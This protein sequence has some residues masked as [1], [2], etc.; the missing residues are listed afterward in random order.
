M[1][2]YSTNPAGK[3]QCPIC[4]YGSGADGK[5]RQSVSKHF[6]KIHQVNDLGSNT[7]GIQSQEDEITIEVDPGEEEE[8]INFTF[9]DDEAEPSWMDAG[10]LEAEEGEI[11]PSPMSAPVK[12]F[13]KSLNKEAGIKKG[14]KKRSAKEQLAWTAQQARLVRWGYVVIDRLVVWWGRGVL[15][16]PSWD[17]TRTEDEWK[18]M[19]ISTTGFLDHHNLSVPVNPDMIFLATLAGAYGPPVRHVAKNKKKAI[20][21]WKNPVKA[22]FARRKLKKMAKAREEGEV[23]DRS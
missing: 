1:A 13:L 20:L 21:S 7:V 22:W 3:F 18:I 9:I 10:V 15:E 2:K 16:D 12:G 4:E 11:R 17:I 5:S 8:E 14:K 19:E 6:N 23:F